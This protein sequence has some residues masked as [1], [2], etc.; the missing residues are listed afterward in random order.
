MIVECQSQELH[1]VLLSGEQIAVRD[2]LLRYEVDELRAA[3][4]A[5]ALSATGLK[6]NLANRLARMAA[7]PS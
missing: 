2:E 1:G 4:R 5:R 6:A 3:L 7:R